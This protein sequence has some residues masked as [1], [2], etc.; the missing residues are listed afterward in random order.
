MNSIYYVVKHKAISPSRVGSIMPF[1]EHDSY[2]KV[3]VSEDGAQ[4]YIGELGDVFGP[5]E[6]EIAKVSLSFESI[7]ESKDPID[8]AVDD[9]LEE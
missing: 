4:A 3:F 9:L 2:Y 7:D 1:M 6:L 5:E 8:K